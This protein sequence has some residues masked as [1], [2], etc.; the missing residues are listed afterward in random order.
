MQ[1][2]TSF[3]HRGTERLQEQ[4]QKDRAWLSWVFVSP[5]VLPPRRLGTDSVTSGSCM[6]S[7][8]QFSKKRGTSARDLKSVQR[9]MLAASS[10]Q[11][12]I[13]AVNCTQWHC[14]RAHC[15]LTLR[16]R[17][18]RAKLL[19][20]SWILLTKPLI[21]LTKR[22]ILPP[23]FANGQSVRCVRASVRCARAVSSACIRRRKYSL[24]DWI[25]SNTIRHVALSLV[26][27]ST[28]EVLG[29]PYYRKEMYGQHPHV[30]RNEFWPE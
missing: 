10:K 8:K 1:T 25:I 5:Q 24:L 22:S 11:I 18:A 7:C 30:A 9:E 4:R 2:K 23:K 13:C 21:L 15:A 20:K 17:T 16:A 29:K 6:R 19:P 3:K 28:L 27:P 14:V 26:N 12:S